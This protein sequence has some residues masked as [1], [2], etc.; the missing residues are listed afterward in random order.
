VPRLIN[1]RITMAKQRKLN[2]GLLLRAIV[3]S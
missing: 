1:A 3:S 2:I